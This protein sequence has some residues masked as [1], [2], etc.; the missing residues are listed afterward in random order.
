MIAHVVGVFHGRRD[1]IAWRVVARLGLVAALLL[2]MGAGAAGAAASANLDREQHRD[3]EAALGAVSGTLHADEASVLAAARYLAT[4]R[5]LA[6]ALAAG[7]L[8]RLPADSVAVATG[9]SADL[10]VVLRSDGAVLVGPADEA[11]WVAGGTVTSTARQQLESTELVVLPDGHLWLLAGAAH[12]SAGGQAVVVVGRRLDGATLATLEERTGC[13]VELRAGEATFSAITADGGHVVRATFTTRHGARMGVAVSMPSAAYADTRATLLGIIASAALGMLALFLVLAFVAVRAAALPLGT[14]AET[15]V[16]VAAGDRS[17]T[18]PEDGPREVAQTAR[19]FNRMIA[20]IAEREEELRAL[21]QHAADEAATMTRRALHDPL[22]DL[23]NR[24][25][26]QDRL[27]QAIAV[28]RRHGGA[29]VT[30]L[31]IDLDGFK[32]VN[33]LHGHQAGDD[34]LRKVA[35]ALTS[36]VRET[37]TVARIGG[38]EFAIVLPGA[39][40]NAAGTVARKVERGIAALHDA[41][42]GLPVGASVGAA[43]FPADAIDPAGLLAFADTRMYRTKVERKGRSRDRSTALPV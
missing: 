34:L 37:D 23:P 6:D 5:S 8:G 13:D 33:D 39:D 4:M 21:H 22:T 43:A 17:R 24:L 28:G 27:E 14:L 3:A 32:G 12:R 2:T 20:S 10:I 9:L 29:P 36:A 30:V 35:G 26:L 18:L 38:D 16:A 11:R 25:L 7:D 40:A 42:R 41:A 15:A 1:G 31:M 19:A